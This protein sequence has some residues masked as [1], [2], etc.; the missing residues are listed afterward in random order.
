MALKHTDR[1][2]D[3]VKPD[4]GRAHPEP[5]KRRRPLKAPRRYRLSFINESTLNRV[6]TIGM[7]RA[8]LRAYIIIVVVFIAFVGAAV[9]SFTPLKVLLPG[10]LKPAERREYVEASRRLDSIVERARVTDAYLSN[11]SDILDDRISTDSLF[12]V[13]PPIDIDDNF[14]KIEASSLEREYVERYLAQ[15]GFD[16]NASPATDNGSE[17]SSPVEDAVVSRGKT[18][19]ATRIMLSQARNQIQ[20]VAPGTVVDVARNSAGKSTVTIQH[21][22]GYLSRYPDLDETFVKPGDTVADGQRLG[23]VRAS[24]SRSRTQWDFA[25]WHDGRRLQPLDYIPF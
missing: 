11:I 24:S 20:A 5:A 17:F 13:P 2:I 12:S 4:E 7:S 9:I 6:W 10:Y 8:R 25:L 14:D 18:P 19:A 23:I 16:L 3:P 1:H 22:D 21:Q 15:S